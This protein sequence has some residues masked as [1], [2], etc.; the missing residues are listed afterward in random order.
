MSGEPS[1]ACRTSARLVGKRAEVTPVDEDGATPSRPLVEADALAT[2]TACQSAVKKGNVTCKSKIVARPPKKLKTVQVDEVGENTR[3]NR[4][5][6][7]QRVSR[8]FED[9]EKP[10]RSR[11]KITLAETS[12]KREEAVATMSPATAKRQRTR[13][14]LASSEPSRQAK[15][16]RRRPRSTSR[17]SE[18]SQGVA[19]SSGNYQTAEEIAS[20]TGS[21]TPDQEDDTLPTPPVVVETTKLRRLRRVWCWLV[22]N[23]G[24]QGGV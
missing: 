12:P 11:K 20:D 13:A 17:S 22:T 24:V 23:D 14:E 1:I 3:T 5:D 21:R 8:H 18:A 19:S 16:I 7:T 2:T 10:K 15:R 4:Q 6:R 9:V